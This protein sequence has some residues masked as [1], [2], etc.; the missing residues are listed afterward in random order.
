MRFTVSSTALS[1]RLAALSRV[2]N[3][4]TSM[5]ILGDFLPDV[6]S[7][8]TLGMGIEKTNQE[9]GQKATKTVSINSKQEALDS[10]ETVFANSITLQ[11]D[12]SYAERGYI[13]PD[14]T[15]EEGDNAQR[16]RCRSCRAVFRVAWFGGG[17]GKI[18]RNEG[19]IFRLSRLARHRKR[20][21]GLLY[22]EEKALYT[23]R[24]RAAATNGR[25]LDAGTGQ[26]Y[27][28]RSGEP[29]DRHQFPSTILFINANNGRR[30]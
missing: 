2:I 11:S 21:D 24:W 23:G 1:S 16:G 28:W 12:S 25:G 15:Q 8:G 27:K 29:V 9:T 17:Y 3:S 14:Q 10:K 7:D 5:P 30:T 19:A 22:G 18:R 6:A 20:S 26:R 4:K 13:Q